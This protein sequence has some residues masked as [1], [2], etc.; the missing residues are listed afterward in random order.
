MLIWAQS[1]LEKPKKGE[2]S[3]LSQ[4]SKLHQWHAVHLIQMNGR[5]STHHVGESVEGWVTMNVLES[6]KL[7][8][9]MPPPVG[10]AEDQVGVAHK[11]RTQQGPCHQGQH[12]VPAIDLG[13]VEVVVVL[14]V[15]LEG[16]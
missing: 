9:V 2:G 10:M 8:W 3:G 1:G 11:G 5:H 12:L 16:R 4:R 7:L 15:G 14:V 6:D 13:E